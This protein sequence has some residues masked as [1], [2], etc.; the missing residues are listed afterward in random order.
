MHHKIIYVKIRFYVKEHH[1]KS[2]LRTH[3]IRNL[4]SQNEKSCHR[5]ALKGGG[6]SRCRPLPLQPTLWGEGR[7]TAG[8][9]RLLEHRGPS[10]AGYH[11]PGWRGMLAAGHH[12]HRDQGGEESRWAFGFTRKFGSG[13]SGNRKIGFSE[14]TPEICLKILIPD[15]SGTRQI[16]YG[17]G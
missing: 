2:L 8:H 6:R 1:V 12:H 7:S 5:N 16:G 3:I 17:F 14:I 13:N 9:H 15:S 4:Q 10:S 11:S